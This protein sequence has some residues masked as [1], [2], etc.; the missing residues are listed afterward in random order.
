[1]DGNVVLYTILFLSIA[2]FVF[3]LVGLPLYVPR[4]IE[5]RVQMARA[6]AR[7]EL[8]AKH[9]SCALHL[10]A[11]ECSR[12]GSCHVCPYENTCTGISYAKIT[13]LNGD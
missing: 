5:A 4:Y 12:S 3:F 11:T 7:E 1:M 6:S 9:G 10:R 13:Y 8:N 2:V